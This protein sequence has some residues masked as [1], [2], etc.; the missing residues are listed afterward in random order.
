MACRPNIDNIRKSCDKGG[1]AA[2][3]RG[4]VRL[5]FVED[6]QSIPDP[7]VNT[8]VISSDIVM[9]P[10]TRPIAEQGTGDPV[11]GTFNEWECSEIGSNYSFTE[12]GEA[13][14]GFGVHTLTMFL[15]RMSAAKNKILDE[16]RGGKEFV[17]SH[18]DRNEIPWLMG[19][20]NGGATVVATPGTDINGRNGYN[21]V[22]SWR[23][24]QLLYRYNGAFSIEAD[25]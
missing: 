21:V 11:P 14:D 22:I 24:A 1:N 23:A 19:N 10:D 12:E 6:I 18:N 2:G 20:L 4:T 3:V 25:V 9:V 16:A 7:D 13:E 8:Y 17:T 15:P 5:A